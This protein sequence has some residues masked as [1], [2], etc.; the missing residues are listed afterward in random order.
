M[1]I[2]TVVIFAVSLWITGASQLLAN[3]K[4]HNEHQM[5]HENVEHASH[6]A[7]C[8]GTPWDPRC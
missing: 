3:T 6:K 1:K 7:H 8:K 4:L 2:S 5:K